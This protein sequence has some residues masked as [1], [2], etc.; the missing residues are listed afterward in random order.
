NEVYVYDVHNH[1]FHLL[2]HWGLD[3][4]NADASGLTLDPSGAS[5]DLWVVDRIDK[6]VYRYSDGQL[7]RSGSQSAAE[8]FILAV[9]NTHPE[10]IAAP[11]GGGSFTIG[12][13][14]S[15]GIGAAGEVDI[16]TFQATA[17]QRL[18]FD[19]QGGTSTAF[20]RWALTDP[21]GTQLFSG[22]FADQGVFAL[23]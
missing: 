21:S 3:A 11:P 13:V 7:R 22:T 15:D 5:N 9:A 19:S 2:G 1:A 6:V 4:R 16:W 23:T 8:T 20:L 17:G 10:W 14:V 12:S 18:F